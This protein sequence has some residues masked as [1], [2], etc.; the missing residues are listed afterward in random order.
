[1]ENK[2][3]SRLS[4]GQ[5]DLTDHRQW[6]TSFD[7]HLCHHTIKAQLYHTGFFFAWCP[8]HVVQFCF[9]INVLLNIL[10]RIYFRPAVYFCAL[11]FSSLGSLYINKSLQN[12][13]VCPVEW[14]PTFSVLELLRPM[15]KFMHWI[16]IKFIDWCIFV[17]HSQQQ[18]YANATNIKKHTC[19][20]QHCM[21]SLVRWLPHPVEVC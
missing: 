13:W 15:Y 17:S 8:E 6:H 14:Q 16:E 19:V 7:F 3:L 2:H 1:M 9:W 20:F 21:V 5:G 11:V 18:K 10:G 12:L 4:P